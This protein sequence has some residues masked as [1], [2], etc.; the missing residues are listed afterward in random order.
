M[1]DDEDQHVVTAGAIVT[2]TVCLT[3]KTMDTMMTGVDHLDLDEDCEGVEGVGADANDEMDVIDTDE[4]N[5]VKD[6][7]ADGAGGAADADQAD[8][9]GDDEDV[10][11]K[12]PVWKKPE[13]KKKGGAGGQK[14]A[15]NKKQ[16]QAKKAKQAGGDTPAGEG[17]NQVKY[18]THIFSSQNVLS[19]ISNN[20]LK[21]YETTTLSYVGF[22]LCFF[23]CIIQAAGAAKASD[24]VTSDSIPNKHKRRRR[25]NVR[26]CLLIVCCPYLHS[27]T[28]DCVTTPE[29]LTFLSPKSSRC[30]LDQSNPSMTGQSS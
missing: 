16:K 23:F 9:E 3:R 4:A 1:I 11:K 15:G 29:K 5:D 28:V 19:S 12:V 2:V 13:K 20:N 21:N 6:V 10:K 14:G 26:T 8:K 22:N 24:H 25:K 27:T 7:A 17:A 18:T 30:Y